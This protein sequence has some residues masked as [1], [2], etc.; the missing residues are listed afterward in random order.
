MGGA[1]LKDPEPFLKN[2]ILFQNK[3]RN[4][5]AFETAV[6]R[7]ELGYIANRWMTR[8]VP[9]QSSYYPRSAPWKPRTGIDHFGD[10]AAHSFFSSSSGPLPRAV[11]AARHRA[12]RRLPREQ[13]G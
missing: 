10:D 2:S 11:A 9:L 7:W 6:A 12:P 1:F 4:D 8:L 3:P 5:A 13:A